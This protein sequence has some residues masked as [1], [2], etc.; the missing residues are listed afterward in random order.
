M[1][2]KQVTFADIAEYTGFS[3]L[4]DLQI[5]QSSGFSDPGKS[6]KRS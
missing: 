4:H 3:K 2:K 6:G 5:F 1:A